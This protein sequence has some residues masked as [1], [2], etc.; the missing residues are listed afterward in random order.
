[1]IKIDLAANLKLFIKQ[2]LRVL[3]V[4]SVYENIEKYI[5]VE[6]NE[7]LETVLNIK[8]TQCECK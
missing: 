5:Q 2:D 8:I 4:Y 1:M 3:Y 7:A 6:W